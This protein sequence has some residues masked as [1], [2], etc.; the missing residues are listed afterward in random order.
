MQHGTLGMSPTS[1]SANSLGVKLLYLVTLFHGPTG[2]GIR[3]CGS[4]C[5]SVNKLLSPGLTAEEQMGRV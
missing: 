1:M 5:G 2:S 4:L 3:R